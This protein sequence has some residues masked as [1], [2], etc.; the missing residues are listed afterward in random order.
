[1]PLRDAASESGGDVL[2]VRDG[3]LEQLAD[4]VVVQVVDDASAVALA[5]HESAMSQLPNDL[6]SPVRHVF[7]LAE[8][9]FMCAGVRYWFAGIG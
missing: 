6:L 2:D 4:V 8:Q 5:D 7:S 1:M 3:L 9:T